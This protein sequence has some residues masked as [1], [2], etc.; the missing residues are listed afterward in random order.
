VI[1]EHS[2]LTNYCMSSYDFVTAVEIGKN[3][4]LFFGPFC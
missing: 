2:H 4:W 1:E 3:D